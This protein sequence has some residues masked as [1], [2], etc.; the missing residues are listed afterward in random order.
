LSQLFIANALIE[1]FKSVHRPITIEQN[2]DPRDGL[3]K[4]VFKAIIK[5]ARH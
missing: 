1:K 2:G 3:L 4:N 5:M